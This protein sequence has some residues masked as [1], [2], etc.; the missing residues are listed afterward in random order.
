M[1]KKFLVLVLAAFMSVSMFAKGLTNL[2]SSGREIFVMKGNVVVWHATDWSVE[3]D[4]VKYVDLKLWGSGGDDY[5][6]VYTFTG[7]QKDGIIG[8]NSFS[9]VDCED[10]TWIWK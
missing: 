2:P 4:S 8:W 6:K 7:N 5:F 1:K 9:V 10:L 3:I